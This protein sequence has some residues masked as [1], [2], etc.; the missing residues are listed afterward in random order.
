[1]IINT[2]ELDYKISQHCK[3]RYAERIMCRTDQLEINRYVIQNEDKIKTDI[4]KMIQYG[5]LIYSGK[6]SQKDG[7]GDVIDVYVRDTW[8]VLVDNKSHIV[9]TLY[10]VDLGL[11][12]DFNKS[13]VCKMIEKLDEYK[14][15]LDDTRN[16]IEEENK[17]YRTMIDEA[18]AQ[19][20]EH[21][22]NAKALDE[23]V[24]AY[25][26]IISNNAVLLSQA[27]KDVVNVVNQLIGKKQF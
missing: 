9:V 25:K 23:L 14:T 13:Y 12:D 17:K 10:R 7:K 16:K 11:D 22:A 1:M 20:N 18:E 26:S 8:V 6:Q 24:V 21:R 3:E 27:N 19:A 5:N 15:I 2:N 4:L